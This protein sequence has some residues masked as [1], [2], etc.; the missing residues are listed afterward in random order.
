MIAFF[1]ML[2]TND[3]MVLDYRMDHL[4]QLSPPKILD[5]Y[6]F[7][8]IYCLE[9]MNEI[10]DL[11]AR[12]E[13]QEYWNHFDQGAIQRI[14]KEWTGIADK[15]AVSSSTNIALS[16]L[17]LWLKNLLKVLPTLASWCSL[18]AC[19]SEGWSYRELIKF[20]NTIRS[21]SMCSDK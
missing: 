16:S 19:C 5:R 3:D 11:T 17:S 8:C 6:Q 21:V 4:L 18:L 12:N 14:Q 2:M 20:L 7:C 13:F 9:N 15:L 1:D 10:L